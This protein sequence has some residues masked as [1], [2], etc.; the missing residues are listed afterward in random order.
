MEV[1]S[2]R[3][4]RLGF[5][6]TLALEL[7]IPFGLLDVDFDAL[8]YSEANVV[9]ALGI[10]WLRFKQ[11]ISVLCCYKYNGH[12]MISMHF[13]GVI[14]INVKMQGNQPYGTYNTVKH[15]TIL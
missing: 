6:K 4:R 12:L 2:Y 10:N 1:L 14:F 15:I 8:E 3:C 13:G 11:T 7:H 5:A 9:P